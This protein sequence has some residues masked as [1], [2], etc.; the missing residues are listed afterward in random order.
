MSEEQREVHTA[1]IRIE[2]M[3]NLSCPRCGAVF[4]D[5]SG[6]MALTCSAAGCGCGFCAWCLQDCGNE[7]DAHHHV[8][9]ECRAKPPG[10]DRFFGD[11][12]VWKRV[13]R[14]RVGREIQEFLNPKPE[15]LQEQILA[16]CRQQL[17]D[18]GLGDMVPRAENGMDLDELVA[19][20]MQFNGDD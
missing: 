11:I 16:A 20:Q 8:A 13:H 2:S 4:L 19:L 12:E 1:R 18:F 7:K 6:S 17:A 9:N 3:L 10:Q 15:A 5:F 14:E